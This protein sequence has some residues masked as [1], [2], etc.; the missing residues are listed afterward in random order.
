M[1][2]LDFFFYLIWIDFVKTVLVFAM[3][4][5]ISFYWDLSYFVY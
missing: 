2:N 4:F 3:T 5:M 1:N